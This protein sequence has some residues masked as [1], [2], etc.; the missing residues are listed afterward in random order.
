MTFRFKFCPI[1]GHQLVVK[2]INNMQRNICSA[3]EYINFENPIVGAAAIILNQQNQILMVK[4]ASHVTYP[5]LWC[6]PCGYV[7]YDEDI[8]TA[9]V[10]EVKEETGLDVICGEVF[11][12]HSNFH[13]PK[14]HTVGV[15]F[16]CEIVG[17]QAAASDDASELGWFELDKLPQLAFPTDYLILRKL[18]NKLC[19]KNK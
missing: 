15:W 18:T 16:C 2:T 10:R 5:G 7:E 3:C 13:N 4:R 8:R 14:Q 12:V 19:Q 1:C 9:V 6:I 11:D 17:G